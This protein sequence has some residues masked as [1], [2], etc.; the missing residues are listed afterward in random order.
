MLDDDNQTILTSQTVECS[1]STAV[2]EIKQ[3]VK[4]Y[5]EEYERSQQLPEGMEI[6]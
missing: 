5:E 1:P 3:K 2:D 4:A 6:E